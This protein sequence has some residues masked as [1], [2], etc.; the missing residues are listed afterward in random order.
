MEFEQVVIAQAFTPSN[1][2]QRQADLCEFKA[3]L[4]YSFRTQVYRESPSSQTK[5]NRM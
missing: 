1:Q 5:E 4:V 2:R 3:S